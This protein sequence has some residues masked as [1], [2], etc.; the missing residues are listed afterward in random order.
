M[1]VFTQYVVADDRT[2]HTSAEVKRIGMLSHA[3]GEKTGRWEE[4]NMNTRVAYR[5]GVTLAPN[6]KCISS[7]HNARGTLKL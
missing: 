3:F 2:A 7:T 5:E 6:R 1:G 4:V